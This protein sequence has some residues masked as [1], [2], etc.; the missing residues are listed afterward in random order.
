MFDKGKGI[1]KINDKFSFE[2]EIF[3][4]RALDENKDYFL[5]IR[6][7]VKNLKEKKRSYEEALQKIK[8]FNGSNMNL[9]SILGQSKEFLTSQ[10]N[11]PMSI[12]GNMGLVNPTY[13][14]TPFPGELV[15]FGHILEQ[16]KFLLEKRVGELEIQL[17]AL[18]QEI[19]DSYIELKKVKYRL[20]SI[21][22]HEGNAGKNSD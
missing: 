4:D 6:E 22:I 1:T 5:K 21:M 18:N 19:E 17:N 9:V 11:Q 12:E 20:L 7:E 13:F 2:K 15:N 16:Y 8:N 3:I 14:G 10:T